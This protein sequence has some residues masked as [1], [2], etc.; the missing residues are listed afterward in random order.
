MDANQDLVEIKLV[1]WTEYTLMTDLWYRSRQVT[2]GV[3]P[4]CDNIGGWGEW[5]KVEV[6]SFEPDS[7]A[8][9]P[10]TEV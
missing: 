9:E 3:I 6:E 8:D 4:G 10:I 7:L 5:R 1:P 2:P